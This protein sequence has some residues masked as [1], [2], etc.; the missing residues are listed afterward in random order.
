MEELSHEEE[1]VSTSDEEQEEEEKVLGWSKPLKKG[2]ELRLQGVKL[3]QSVATLQCT[4]ARLS[5]QCTRCRHVMDITCGQ[6]Q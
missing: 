5:I 6:K 1:E 4:R 2:T 3:S